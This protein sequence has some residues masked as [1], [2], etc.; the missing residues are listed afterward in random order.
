MIRDKKHF[1][2]GMV[3]LLTFFVALGVIYSPVFNGM[4]GLQYA[5]NLFNTISKGSTYYIPDVQKNVNLYQDEKFNSTIALASAEDAEKSAILFEKAGVTTELQGANLT[6]AG[7]L[8]GLMAV[9]LEDADL[10]FKNEGGALAAKYGYDAQDAMYHWWLGLNALHGVLNTEGYFSQ[11][12]YVFEVVQK[13]V[14][15]SYNY[16]GIEARKVSEFAGTVT[17]LLV[18]YLVYTV[19]FGFAIFYLFE[20]IGLVMAGDGKKSE[21]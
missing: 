2:M 19:W 4:N 13:A 5:D 10:M 11:A 16:Y 7:D 1:I 20:G 15:P 8:G 3:L 12:A 18:F 9:V 21:A 6:V 14:E 17:G